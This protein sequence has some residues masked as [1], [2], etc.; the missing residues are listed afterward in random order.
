MGPCFRQGESGH[1]H[2]PEYTMLEWYRSD[3][4]YLGIL[5]DTKALI[6]AIAAEVIGRDHLSYRGQAIDLMPVWDVMTVR[7]AY[8]MYAGWDPLAYYDADR[9]DLDMV[10]KIQPGLPVNRPVILKDYPVEAAALARCRQEGGPVAERWELYIGGIELANAFS[11]LTD[12]GEQRRRFEECAQARRRL[13]QAVYPLDE[14]FLMA[15]EAGM[16]PSG[17]IAL[18]VDRLAMLLTDAD[19]IRQ[20][21]SF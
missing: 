19:D 9:F 8:L 16:P 15:L 1:L 14:D 11:E 6:G 4:D 18:G 3:A 5:A 13:G 20:V 7:D 21:R 12:G 2:S 10:E 17:G